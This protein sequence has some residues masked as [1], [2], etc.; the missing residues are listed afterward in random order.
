MNAW[1]ECVLFIV[2]INLKCWNEEIALKVNVRLQMKR[3]V[4]IKQEAQ[5]NSPK[6]N[7]TL[8]A[9]GWVQRK[10]SDVVSF[11]SSELLMFWLLIFE[12]INRLRKFERFNRWTNKLFWMK[13]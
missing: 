8:T 1:H 3:S 10:F 11:I 9:C 13:K 12:N 5:T 2:I 6:I 4:S 7:V